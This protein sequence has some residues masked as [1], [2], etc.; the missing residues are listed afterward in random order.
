MFDALKGMTTPG[1][2]ERLDSPGMAGL[3]GMGGALMA[4]S[5][6]Q[7]HK[8]GAG[9]LLGA[10]GG[11][12][13]SGLLGSQR[14]RRDERMDAMMEAAMYKQLGLQVPPDLMRKIEGMYGAP[15]AGPGATAAAAMQQP[16]TN[17]GMSAGIGPMSMPMPNMG[18]QGPG[19]MLGGGV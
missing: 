6:P 9:G 1:L 18:L 12:L 19:G 15:A 3:L 11:G 10:A 5:Q 14:A 7:P 2:L 4:A 13:L 16:M 17:S 8:M